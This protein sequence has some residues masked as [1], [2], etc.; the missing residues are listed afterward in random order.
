M[1]FYQ[2]KKFCILCLL[3]TFIWLDRY[4][5]FV[6]KQTYDEGKSDDDDDDCSNVPAV[7]VLQSGLMMTCQKDQSL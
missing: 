7:K 2:V 6:K 4:I 5:F 1:V 3:C